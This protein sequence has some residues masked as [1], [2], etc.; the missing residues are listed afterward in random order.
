MADPYYM[1]VLPS[2]RDFAG[3]L[4]EGTKG[5][6]KSA[7]EQVATELEA[8][9]AK[10]E[11]TV[12][13]AGAAAE[14][15]QNRVADATGKVRVA[16]EQ[17]NKALDTGDP[18][19]IARAEETLAKAR[20]DQET[21][22]KAA[23]NAA[24]D[25]EQAQDR[26]A[27]AAREHADAIEL[28]DSA[29]G[30]YEGSIGGVVGKLGGLAAG[31]G[32]VASAAGLMVEGFNVDAQ[33]DL[34][35]R[36][37]G[38]TGEAAALLGDEV[39]E[40]MRTGV[41]GNAE[42]AAQ[43][44]GALSSQFAYLG[45]EGEQTAAGLSDNFLA[46]TDTFGT[47]MA[48]ATQTAGQLILNGL[49]S[50]V[51][52][53]ADLMTAAMQRVPAQMRDEL[54][55]IINE[56]GTNFRAL[57]FSGE[58]SFGLLVSAAEQGKW[59]LDK[60]GDSL[61][62]FTIRGADMSK[63]ST[64]AYTLIGLS[65]EEM[66]AKVAAGGPAARE[67][68]MATA[69][70]LL[71][72]EN[73]AERA[74]AAIALFGTPLEDLS[75]DQIPQFLEGLTGADAAMAGFEGS[76]QALSDQIS[77]SL[78]GRMDALKGTVSDLAGDA[79]MDLWDAAVRISDWA[80][81]NST[82]LG[83]L[84][85]GLGTLG[86]ILGGI[87][88]GMWAWNAALTAYSTIQAIATGKQLLFN[89]ALLANPITWVVI[90]IAALV[91]GLV[92]FFTQTETGQQI[93]Q[94]FTDAI[95]IGWE[96]IKNAFAVAWAFIQ[97]ILTGL[98]EAIK[99]G[100]AILFTALVIP[101]QIGWNLLSAAISWAWTTI[102]QPTWAL[103]QIGLQALGSF[104]TWVWTAVIQPVW[105]AL[106]TG[107]KWVWDTIIH[108]AWIG[109]QIS[110]DA[111]GQFFGWVWNSVIWPV[112]DALGAGIRWV[113][114]NV[115]HP[116]FE[117]LKTGLGFI[118][119]AFQKAVDWIG[120]QWDRIK[121]ITAAPIRFV[122]DSIYNDGI[123][124]VW[125]K[126]AGWLGLTELD[127]WR[128][129]WM[130]GFAGGGVLPGYT[131]GRD[132]YNFVDPKTGLRIDLGGGEGIM[133]PEFVDAVGGPKAIDDLNMRARKGLPL[134]HAG[135]YAAGGVLPGWEMLTTDIQRAM[136][137]SVAQA[138]P[139]Q[140]IT[141][142]TRYHDV[143]SGYDNHMQ[144]R[145]VD[146]GL[147][148]GPLASWIANEYGPSV[149]ELF[150]DPGPNMV[151]GAPTG[152]IG[153]HSDHVHWAMSHI[154]DPY[155]GDVISEGGQGGTGT[156]PVRSL[157][158]N[159]FSSIMDPIM[160]LIP[161]GPGLFGGLARGLGD[162]MVDGVRE[163]LLGKS[164]SGG[165]GAHGDWVGDPG[166]EQFR[167][168]VERLLREKGHDVGLVGSVLRRM[169]QESGGNPNA[170]NLWDSNAMAGIPSKGLMQ[171]IDPTFQAYMDPGH[172]NIW[173]PEDNLRASMNYAMA[174]Y[175]SL[176]A[177]YDRAG[178]YD[179]GG[180]LMPGTTLSI[181]DTDK[182]EPVFTSPQWNLIKSLVISTAELLDPIRLL[183]R[184]GRDMVRHVEELAGNSRAQ[185]QHQVDLAAA[186]AWD[187]L[188]G[189]VQHAL[190]IADAVGQQW[191]RVSGYL[192]DKA[193]AWSKGEWPIGSARTPTVEPG[194]GWEQFRLDDSLQDVARANLDLADAVIAG[195]LSPGSDP[196]AN[197]IFDVF[198]RDPILPDLARI[199]AGGPN[200]IEAATT[201]ALHAFETGETARLE[202][203]TASNSQL[204]E[205]VLRARDAAIVTGEM[206]QG[207]VN[208]YLNW[209]MASD[210]Q[211]RQGSW[212]EYF[213]HYGGEYGTAQGDWLLSQ[214][215]LGGI[216]GGKFKDSFANLLIE[217]AQSPLLAAP[218]ILDAEGRVIGTQLP[219]AQAEQAP[220]VA[221]VAGAETLAA[222]MTGLADAREAETDEEA[223]PTGEKTIQ[224]EVTLPEGKTA[225][226]V[227]EV[228]GMLRTIDEDVDEIKIKVN[229]ME[230]ESAS[231]TAGVD[232]MV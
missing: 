170:I 158:A 219:A 209:A 167:P 166:V 27:R 26:A 150:W 49:A 32:G 136:A 155:T 19:R 35:N 88:L 169:N 220:T 201:A 68:L 148:G 153:G 190:T 2:F 216:I 70:G 53:A 105:N 59:A 14:K 64:D 73:P 110:L 56:Y 160:E 130:G 144:G 196:V 87:A 80:Q 178:G 208:G 86:G 185:L 197:A 231:V 13:T 206:V 55:E 111:L 194:P 184:D 78:Q 41:A 52:D 198:G 202:E 176:S 165:S 204:T 102:I 83:P 161:E 112:W 65:A 157:V 145:A 60:T 142:G 108:P 20:R 94:S 62:E 141:S 129:K 179:D 79:F 15:A 44:V 225:F 107:I 146:F 229:R 51:E 76:S 154:I 174:T 123:R 29:L 224:V 200:A 203:W 215:G 228:E 24:T 211:G 122:I 57:G 147:P 168:L 207:A 43:A 39:G 230:S 133:R 37:L 81:T 131:P 31:L 186:A 4:K 18:V 8:A 117:G 21:V 91:A 119:T 54:P 109:M 149:L 173:D 199:A 98:W 180:Y 183:A 17:Y 66:S 42:D 82:W 192:N 48:E 16:Q 38:L 143:G 223:P 132:I 77:G 12:R 93:W 159:A 164:G 113:A 11:R 188:P 222:D 175:G 63:A 114:D 47:D 218:E 10:T 3:K 189:E 5:A 58:E 156:S 193:I 191:E 137:A 95:A 92:Y 126:V 171:T 7:G 118:E 116:V 72:V 71:A 23:K 227:E 50:D 221:P 30:E 28:G 205:A 181:N 69:D 134:G 217:T 101:F 106:G 96:W 151:G 45:F 74:N 104:F 121:E 140:Q 85:V 177:A 120:V 124:G 67:A 99:I 182:P 127:E 115:V 75:V 226:T 214:V 213:Q 25:L 34:M 103:M 135:A 22:T 125:N 6:G 100:G 187:A 89:S 162:K 90:A 163:F 84:V 46:F 61:K 232:L 128:P 1:P 152:A 172:G 97:P 210:S 40:V 139:N 212:Q 138:F 33:I 195:D 36:Q 9:V